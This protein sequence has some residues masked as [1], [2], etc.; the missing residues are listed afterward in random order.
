MIN[1]R[2]Y[3]MKKKNTILWKFVELSDLVEILS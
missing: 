2:I 1:T 3:R